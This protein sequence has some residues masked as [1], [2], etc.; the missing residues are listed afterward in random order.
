MHLLKPPSR[1]I[2]AAFYS[3][4]SIQCYSRVL[5]C[6]P[7]YTQAVPASQGSPKYVSRAAR[8][9][10]SGRRRGQRGQMEDARICSEADR[11]VQ[12]EHDRG[13]QCVA[14]QA[15]GTDFALRPM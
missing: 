15:A 13:E 10:D 4:S 3:Q 9:C 1:S 6:E 11:R 5:D 12:T 14:T 7:S 8:V 2:L